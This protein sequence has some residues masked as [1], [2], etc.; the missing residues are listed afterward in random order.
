MLAMFVAVL[1]VTADL[2]MVVPKGFIPDTDNDNFNVT[3]EAAQGTSYYQMIK[4]QQLISSIVAKDPDI[5]SFYASTGGSFGGGGASARLMVNTKPRKERNVS[6][7]EIVNR[8]RPKFSGIPGLRVSL[9]V[10]QAI[11]VGGRMSKSAYD[12][13]LVGPDTQQLYA[14]APKLERVMARMPGLQDVTSDLQI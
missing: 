8:L 6:V 12:F 10:P 3:A 7:T 14:E 9:S 4:Y 13:T 5:D 11:R 2:Y 1:L